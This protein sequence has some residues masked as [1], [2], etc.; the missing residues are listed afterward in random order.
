MKRSLSRS[1]STFGVQ[2]GTGVAIGVGDMA[3]SAAPRM[4]DAPTIAR[5]RRRR[6]QRPNRPGIPGRRL[7]GGGGDRVRSGSTL[8]LPDLLLV[9]P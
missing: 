4:L 3:D 5:V 9:S 2:A 1:R 6:W 8:D 7:C